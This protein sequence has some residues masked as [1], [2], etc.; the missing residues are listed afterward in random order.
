[1]TNAIV[2]AILAVV[3]GLAIRYIVRARKSGAKC[4]GCSTCSGSS[5]TSGCGSEPGS[6]CCH[7]TEE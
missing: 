6:C 3:L 2:I 1:M 7:I 4:I 5:G